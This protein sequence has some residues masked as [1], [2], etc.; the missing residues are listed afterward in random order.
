[1]VVRADQSYPVG[2]DYLDQWVVFDLELEGLFPAAAA[3][4]MAETEV[5]EPVESLVAFGTQ[6]E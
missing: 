4:M 6:V 3:L 1:V 5:A 2:Q